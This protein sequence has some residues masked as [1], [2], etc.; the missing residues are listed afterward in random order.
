M[1]WTWWDHGYNMRYW[2]DRGIIADGS[3]HEGEV[4]MYNA[5][6]LTVSSEQLSANFIHFYVSRG[7]KGMTQ[8]YRAFDNQY[9]KAMQFLLKILSGDAEQAGQ[10][11]EDSGVFHNINVL[12]F[13]LAKFNFIL[14]PPK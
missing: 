2:S 5:L 12:R 8:V 6:P 14:F 13:R 10:V 4:T 3:H 7:Q 11:M 9:G 1:I